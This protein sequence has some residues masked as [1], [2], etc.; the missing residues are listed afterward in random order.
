MRYALINNKAVEAEAGL[1]G[2]CRGCGQ[3][4]IAKCGTIRI[5]HWAHQTTKMCDNWWEPE[6]EWH[7]NWKNNFPK[8]WQEVFLP[9][10]QTQENHIADVCTIHGLVI[11]LQHSHIDPQERISREKFYKNMVWVVDCTRLRY[12]YPRFTKGL[13]HLVA[14]KEP[15]IFRVNCAESCFPSTWLNC[16]VPVLFDF[17]GDGQLD[18]P[19]GLRIPLYCLFPVRIGTSVE[20]AK[21]PR[22]AF[23]KNAL[24]GEWIARTTQRINRLTQEQKKW[25]INDKMLRLSWQLQEIAILRFQAL[26]GYR[27]RRRL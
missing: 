1:K 12:D 25:Q 17:Q 24:N 11:E 16:S 14:T 21:I 7:R 23:V 2:F 8:E 6:T 3:P 9:D 15:G 13:Q 27:K 20:V 19:L 26:Q 5:H 10:I 18:D 22:G 4:V